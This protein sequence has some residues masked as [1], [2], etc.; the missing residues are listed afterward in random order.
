MK[1]RFEFEF[2]D[3]SPNSI[4]FE[5]SPDADERLEIGTEEGRPILYA[6]ASGLITLAKILLKMGLGAYTEGFHVHLH[7]DFNAD[8]P[9]CLAV[10]VLG[11]AVP[12]TKVPPA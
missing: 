9:E 7:K 12:S 5:Y 4:T 8:E 6:N 10:M 1:H 3:E 2:D 11:D